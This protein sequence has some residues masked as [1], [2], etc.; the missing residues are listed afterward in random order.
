[1]FR[2]GSCS[3][4]QARKLHDARGRARFEPERVSGLWTSPSSQ[5]RRPRRRRAKGETERAIG[6]L[7]KPLDGS[8]AHGNGNLPATGQRAD[9][10]TAS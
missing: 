1:M 3:R 7:E 9:Q 6:L 2:P 10:N 8:S 5:R 4:F